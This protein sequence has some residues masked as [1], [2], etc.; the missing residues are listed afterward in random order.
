MLKRIPKKSSKEF[1]VEDYI[2]SYL[3]IKFLNGTGA[4]IFCK[5]A[6]KS[7]FPCLKRATNKKTKVKITIEVL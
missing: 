7:H 5:E 6:I 3:H 4:R 2:G 1:F